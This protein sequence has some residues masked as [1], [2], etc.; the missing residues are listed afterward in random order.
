MDPFAH[1][2]I[3]WAAFFVA[4]VMAKWTRLTPVLFFLFMGCVLVN[5]RSPPQQ[6]L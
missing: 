5:S 3:I 4:V 2:A 6:T 1:L